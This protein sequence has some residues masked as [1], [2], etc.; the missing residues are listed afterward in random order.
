M[1]QVVDALINDFL[2]CDPALVDLCL[3]LISVLF[4][5]LC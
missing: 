4:L 1:H 5:E 3:Q 2:L